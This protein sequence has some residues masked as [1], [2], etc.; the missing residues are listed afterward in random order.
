MK[1]LNAV[2]G[3]M[4]PSMDWMIRSKSLSLSEAKTVLAENSIESFVG[5]ADTAR[6]LSNELG[7][8]IPAERRNASLAVGETAFVAQYKGPRLVEGATVLPDGARIDFGL[9]TRIE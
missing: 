2:S 9:V 5:H 3:N 6:V 4:F 7:V 1:I 8:E